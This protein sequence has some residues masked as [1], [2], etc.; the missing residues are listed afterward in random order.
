MNPTVTAPMSAVTTCP[1]NG[2]RSFKSKPD[3][4]AFEEKNRVLHGRAR[5]HAYACEDCP[6]WH[7]TAMPPGTSTMATSRLDE[8]LLRSAGRP[9]GVR[10][11]DRAEVVRLKASGMTQ[12]KI[13]DRLGVS[14]Q[15]VGY[16]LRKANGGMSVTSSTLIV[17]PVK[18]AVTLAQV[19]DEEAALLAKLEEIKRTKERLLEATRMKVEVQGDNIIVRKNGG[20]ITLAL[21][22]I[23]QLVDCVPAARA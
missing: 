2:K 13:A 10:N 20:Q 15:T 17:R 9:T 7:L 23:E 8:A 22:D 16:H 12:Q 3:A 14:P 1:R 4:V 18:Q 19:T 5:Q 21:T 6:D 11:V